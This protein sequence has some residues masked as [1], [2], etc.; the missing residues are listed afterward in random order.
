[1]R[2]TY[3]LIIK[4]NNMRLAI[5]FLAIKQ[6]VI[7]FGLPYILVHS[8]IV[9]SSEYKRGQ[10]LPFPISAARRIKTIAHRA[11]TR[12]HHRSLGFPIRSLLSLRAHPQERRSRRNTKTTI[13]DCRRSRSELISP[14]FTS[15]PI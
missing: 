2:N 3:K 14:D 5:I 11:Q 1:M 6:K 7:R 8:G 9:K 15:A 10:P 13:Y 4:L 12:I